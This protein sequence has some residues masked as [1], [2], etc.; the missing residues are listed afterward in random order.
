MKYLKR[1]K[2]FESFDVEDLCDYLQEVF[3]KFGIRKRPQNDDSDIDNPIIEWYYD[4][5]TIFID[6]IPTENGLESE[7]RDELKR[8]KP[9]IEK[10]IGEKLLFSIGQNGYVSSICWI[11]IDIFKTGRERW[12]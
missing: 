8:I 3:D 1:Y 10:R 4:D 7:I 2:T 12:G 9:T 5:E 11:R 6:N